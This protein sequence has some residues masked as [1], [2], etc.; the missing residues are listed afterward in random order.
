LGKGR[1]IYLAADPFIVPGGWSASSC[2]VEPGSPVVE[3]VETVQR[4]AGARMGQDIWR[5]KLPPFRGDLYEKQADLCLTGNYVYDRN[6]PHLQPNNLPSGGSYTYDRAPTGRPDVAG[7]AQPIP[8]AQGRLTNRVAAYRTRAGGQTWIVSQEDKLAAEWI[9]SWV[10]P[11][12]V[13]VTFDLTRRVPLSKLRFICSGVCPAFAVSGSEDGRS[14]RQLSSGDECLAGEDVVDRAVKLRG[15]YRYL[16]LHFAA[17]RHGGTFEL[18]EVELWARD[19]R[20]ELS[21]RPSP[22]CCP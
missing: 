22:T 3:L 11:A 7:A 10:D 14:W 6:E 12:P 21:R 19:S 18:C 2:L 5:F 17:R 16:R 4:L 20:E 13:T 15:A 8:F 9:V 1:V